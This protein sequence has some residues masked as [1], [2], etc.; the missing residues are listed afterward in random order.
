MT[1]DNTRQAKR[2]GRKMN[3]GDV[4]ES[5]S[6]RMRKSR[7]GHCRVTG[8]LVR[9][10]GDRDYFVKDNRRYFCEV[11]AISRT[12]TGYVRWQELAKDGKKDSK[13]WPFLR[14]WQ[15]TYVVKILEN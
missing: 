7:W 5:T 13:K 8:E 3:V 9:K 12:T 11:R 2:L 4:F 14:Y 1:E 10:V 15:F 6:K